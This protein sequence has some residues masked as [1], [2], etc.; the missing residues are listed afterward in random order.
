VSS[1]PHLSSALSSWPSRLHLGVTALALLGLA[2]LG[3][4]A[5][6]GRLHLGRNVT[7]ASPRAAVAPEKAPDKAAAR[8][9]R[10]E[11]GR[12]QIK[13]V[14]DMRRLFELA[15]S[16]GFLGEQFDEAWVF[17]YTGGFLECKLETDHD[18]KAITPGPLPSKWGELFAQDEELPTGKPE[19]LRREGHL[20]LAAL[21]PQLPIN[22]LAPY[23]PHLGGMFVCGPAGPLHQLV[24]LHLE[25]WHR[26]RYRLFLTVARD[27]ANQG[28]RF[29]LWSEQ[30]M[31]MRTGILPRDPSQEEY[32]A[33]G[34]KDLS[35]GADVTILDRQVGRSRLRVKA[36]FLGD[37]E[38][39]S[40]MKK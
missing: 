10:T 12:Y 36:R 14:E 18:G 20:I 8:T 21:R 33:E 24:S 27:G 38:V 11:G 40:A 4:L 7:P 6:A 31:I 3:G 26:I 22:Q 30:V 15:G 37:D 23:F 25:A 17:Q 39:R 34:G 9:A 32:H 16:G 28:A 35:P 5:L 19:A 13:P 1:N 29:N 2:T